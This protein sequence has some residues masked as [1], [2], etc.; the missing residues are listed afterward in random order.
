MSTTDDIAQCVI[1]GDP[2][3]YCPGHPQWEFQ[4][5]WTAHDDGD[6]SG[7]NRT[8]EC[9]AGYFIGHV[10]ELAMECQQENIE[11]DGIAGIDIALQE[12]IKLLV[13]Y[14]TLPHAI[15]VRDWLQLDDY[16]D[17]EDFPPAPSPRTAAFPLATSQ[18]A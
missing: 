10:L 12:R 4:A 16:L 17:K 13:N 5:Q 15:Q 1:C 11:E 2:I 18:E 14:P 6:H 9:Y 7:C 8:T 3:D